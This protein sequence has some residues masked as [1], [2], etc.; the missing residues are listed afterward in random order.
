MGKSVKT[1]KITLYEIE[2]L[3]NNCFLLEEGLILEGVLYFSIS[4]EKGL[5]LEG[6][7]Y[8]VSQKFGAYV[9]FIN[10]IDIFT[11]ERVYTPVF[12]I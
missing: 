10:F 3:K 7:F 8:R 1:P 12:C 6:V 9:Y 4:L 5:I 11:Q 2:F